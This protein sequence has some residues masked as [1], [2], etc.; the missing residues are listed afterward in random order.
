M[1]SSRMP[2]SGVGAGSLGPLGSEIRAR[3]LPRHPHEPGERA[4]LAHSDIDLETHITEAQ[5]CRA[6]DHRSSRPYTRSYL[7]ASV[8][9]HRTA[10]GRRRSYRH[11]PGRSQAAHHICRLYEERIER[12]NMNTLARLALASPRWNASS[13]QIPHT[14]TA[15]GLPS[16]LPSRPRDCAGLESALPCGNIHSSPLGGVKVARQTVFRR[17]AGRGLLDCGSG[18]RCLEALGWREPGLRNT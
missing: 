11:V 16:G 4:H 7:P 5:L 8:P 1:C 18:K 9:G 17:R 3:R 10:S 15:C 12:P 14:G 13:N 6:S 2:G